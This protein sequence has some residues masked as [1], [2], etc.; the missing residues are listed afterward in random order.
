MEELI[1]KCKCGVFL[2]VNEY[3]DYYQTVQDW[4][5]EHNEKEEPFDESKFNYKE[6]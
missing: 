1:K 2:T 5:N 3:R 6:D 4:L